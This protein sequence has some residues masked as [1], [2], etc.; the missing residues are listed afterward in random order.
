[1]GGNWPC[2]DEAWLDVAKGI[3]RIIGEIT[4]EGAGLRFGGGI[5]QDSLNASPGGNAQRLSQRITSL[6]Q[7]WDLLH[8]KLG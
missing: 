4:T 8:Q 5:L 1:M 6:Q 3:L 2:R 7:D